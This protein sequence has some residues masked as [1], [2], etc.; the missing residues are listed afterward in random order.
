[1]IIPPTQCSELH[2]N[3]FESLTK[4]EEKYL[5][6]LFQEKYE[7]IPSGR[8]DFGDKPDVIVTIST[9]ETIGI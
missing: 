2:K 3:K 1:M 5:F 4:Q 7:A 9:E 8:A 6:K